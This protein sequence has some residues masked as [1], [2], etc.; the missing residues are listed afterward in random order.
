MKKLDFI[1]VLVAVILLIFFLARGYSRTV[2]T[3][4][5]VSIEEGTLETK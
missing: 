3:V 5:D 4:E 1:M 2:G